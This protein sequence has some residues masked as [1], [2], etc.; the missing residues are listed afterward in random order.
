VR[1]GELITS[2][3]RIVL[4]NRYLWFFGFFAGVPSLN[5]QLRSSDFGGDLPPMRTPEGGPVVGGPTIGALEVVFLLV[6]LVVFVVFLVLSVISQGALTESVAAHHRGERRGFR[7][8]WRAGRSTFWRI[9][10]FV[11]LALLIAFGLLLA[12][13]LPI[14]GVVVGAFTLTDAVMLQVLAVVGAVLLGIFALV[15]VLIPFAV[16]AQHAVREI[17][18][19]G[20][21]VM[22]SLRGGW[23]LF[24]RNLGHSLLLFLIQQGIGLGAGIVVALAA[25]VLSLPAIVL[26]AT[27][28]SAA[29]AVA[30]VTGV[31]VIPLA[32]AAVGAI[33]A[34]SHGLWTLAYLRLSTAPA[35]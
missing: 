4:H 13:A 7:A 20:K 28:S 10:G 30:I 21:T 1:Y 15:L 23:S 26:I 12:V 2:T 31:I 27:G 11:L 34:F 25:L 33:G 29:I 8:A 24:R 5:F 3:F 19:A 22:E 17:V 32:L 16:I 14:V 18:L 9:L 6:V 35:G